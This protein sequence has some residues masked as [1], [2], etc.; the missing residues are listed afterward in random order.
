[1]FMADTIERKSY[2]VREKGKHGGTLG[3]SALTVLR[4]LLFV[5]QKREGCL[6]PSL[7]TIAK[8][9]RMSKPTVIKAI[10]TLVLMGFLTVYRRCK[11]IMTPLGI[12]V[13]QDSNCY[14]YH[15]PTGLGALGWA[16]W[17]P[18]V[19]FSGTSDH[20]PVSRLSPQLAQPKL[21]ARPLPVECRDAFLQAVAA[22]LRGHE[23]GPGIV[24]RVCAETQR[25]FFNPP[26]LSAARDQSKYR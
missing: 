24:H 9:A 23:V 8:L 1:M 13:C 19:C 11:R 14:E 7:E 22:E 12:R 3:R 16:I 2:A 5:V 21:A 26:D 15:P 25:Q 6:Y 10:T 17:K 4:V 18:A 20:A